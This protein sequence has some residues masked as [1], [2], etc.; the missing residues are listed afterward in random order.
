MLTLIVGLQSQFWKRTLNTVGLEI[1]GTVPSWWGDWC[2]EPCKHSARRAA[3]TPCFP[4]SVLHKMMSAPSLGPLSQNPRIRSREASAKML[5]MN[6]GYCSNWSSG[7][8]SS[9]SCFTDVG[10]ERFITPRGHHTQFHYLL[11][12]GFF[13]VFG[14]Y[15]TCKVCLI[16]TLCN[17]LEKLFPLYP[18]PH[19]LYGASGL[20]H[21]ALQTKWIFWLT[22]KYGRNKESH[23]SYTSLC[24]TM[25]RCPLSEKGDPVPKT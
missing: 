3:D 15:P 5:D 11:F 12:H 21:M 4:F 10:N 14:P 8:T 25:K 19:H 24:S 6:R 20:N 1:F 13:K 9:T 17:W 18:W 16:L 22:C 7:V 23:M 2:G